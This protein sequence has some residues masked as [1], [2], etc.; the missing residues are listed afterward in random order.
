MRI[1]GFFPSFKGTLEGARLRKT[2]QMLRKA[3]PLCLQIFW[4]SMD[5]S[6][7]C[8]RW[9]VSDRDI[10]NVKVKA[11]SNAHIL[12]KDF[13]ENC[14]LFLDRLEWV[15]NTTTLCYFYHNERHQ[16]VIQGIY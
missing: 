8:W 9:C 5:I 1:N 10:I 6:D 12:L 7:K 2:Y 13:L 16:M 3:K 11:N 4:S 15:N 14:L